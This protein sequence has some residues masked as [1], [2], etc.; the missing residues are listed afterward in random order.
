ML[1]KESMDPTKS[2]A[3]PKAATDAAKLQSEAEIAR[4]T[5][6]TRHKANSSELHQH[7]E[8]A[9]VNAG[10]KGDAPTPG[11]ATLAQP[12]AL[13]ELTL[14]AFEQMLRRI[15]QDIMEPMQHDMTRMVSTNQ[16]PTPV[17][18]MIQES[19]N[20]VKL[21]MVTT[22][23][24]TVNVEPIRKQAQQ[25]VENKVELLDADDEMR[26]DHDALSRCYAKGAADFQK[27]IEHVTGKVQEFNRKVDDIK[28]ELTATAKWQD[29]MQQD[30]QSYKKRLETHASAK[31][32]ATIADGLDGL[33]TSMRAYRSATD[34]RLESAQ[35]EVAGLVENAMLRT[36][37]CQSFTENVIHKLKAYEQQ[38]ATQAFAQELLEL[39]EIVTDM[40]LTLD[41]Q[42]YGWQASISGA[43]QQWLDAVE[44]DERP[45]LADHLIKQELQQIVTTDKLPALIVSRNT[46]P[47]RTEVQQDWQRLNVGGEETT[48]R[49]P[50]EEHMQRLQ[51]RDQGLTIRQLVREMHGEQT[52]QRQAKQALQFEAE[53][54]MGIEAH[55][56]MKDAA[57]VLRFEVAKLKGNETQLQE[58]PFEWHW[59][60]V[61]QILQEKVKKILQFQAGKKPQACRHAGTQTRRQARTHARTQLRSHARTHAQR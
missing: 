45:T 42:Q 51:Q 1:A 26:R 4:E 24:F 12:A 27:Q 23:N 37:E 49:S 21:E 57:A 61:K 5:A 34:A 47:L 53:K 30:M 36:V 43:L 54:M 40:Q 41:A 59:I 55:M 33:T 46:Q 6:K 17:K 8:T 14:V 25:T 32:M 35:K 11:T 16:L 15:V 58:Q 38:D 13:S 52:L 10:D 56:K 22:E 9:A 39:S 3:R 7:L 18:R 48:A 2:G 44:A 19:S 20:P 50:K 31:K 29:Q 60:H 28:H